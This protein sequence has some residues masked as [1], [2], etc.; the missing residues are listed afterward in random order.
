MQAVKRVILAARV[1]PSG[2]PIRLS[3]DRKRAVRRAVAGERKHDGR[4]LAFYLPDS[5]WAALVQV[6]QVFLRIPSLPRALLSAH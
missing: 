2:P 6:T 3:F 4:L 1:G 5:G